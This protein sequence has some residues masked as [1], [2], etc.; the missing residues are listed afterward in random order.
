MKLFRYL[1][2]FIR[3]LWVVTWRW[4]RDASCAAHRRRGIFK[5][6]EIPTVLPF[7]CLLHSQV[8]GMELPTIH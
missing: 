2:T 7:Q 1:P 4:R 3:R 6:R 5:H 8:E